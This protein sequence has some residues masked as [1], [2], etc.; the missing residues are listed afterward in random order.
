[1]VGRHRLDGYSSKDQTYTVS[2]F[3][4][5]CLRSRDCQCA[6]FGLVVALSTN[7][8]PIKSLTDS[9]TVLLLNVLYWYLY[10]CDSQFLTVLSH[11]DLNLF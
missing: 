3:S 7:A 10:L 11:N 1:M 9:H 2:V 4:P 6:L 5:C 8:K